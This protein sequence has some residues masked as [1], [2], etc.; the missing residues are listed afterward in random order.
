MLPEIGIT[1]GAGLALGFL[2]AWALG[3]SREQAQDQ[4]ATQL[5]QQLA[6]RS[7]ALETTQR[8]RDTARQE[9][10]TQQQVAA[11]RDAKQREEIAR[12]T[13]EG[14][15]FEQDAEKAANALEE[16]RVEITK[17]RN[18]LLDSETERASLKT[19]LEAEQKHHTKNLATLTDQFKALASDILKENSQTFAAQNQT[20]IDH[21]LEP[22]GK[23][24]ERL[25][26][27]TQELEVKREGAYGAVLTEINNMKDTHQKLRQETTQLVQA[28][29]SPKARGNWGELQLK[30]CIE[31]AGMVERASFDT[32]VFVRGEDQSLRPDCVI[33]L[34]NGRTII[35][36]AKTPFDAYLDAT[37]S[38]DEVQ[39]AALL[40]AHAARVREHLSQL[41]AKA[42]WRQF[43]ESPDFVVCFLS[44]EVLFSAALEQEPGLIEFGSNSNVILATPTTLIALLKAVAY[45][46]QQMEITRNALAIKETGQ[47]LYDKLAT[48]Q[49]YFSKMGRALESAVGQYNSLVGCI[50]GRDSVFDRAREL[51]QLGIGKDDLTELS[52]LNSDKSVPRILKGKD[53]RSSEFDNAP[54]SLAAR[55][56]ETEA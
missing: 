52:P 55:M 9:I 28:L 47:R 39:R 11:E 27:T 49:E 46:W 23:A 42:Y 8:E 41:S 29:R 19:A 56:E 50:E 16:Q 26:S 14:S 54:L 10:A 32:E 24:L 33:H 25:Q 7:A 3:R 1:L 31:F 17:L 53:W 13:A 22:M 15:R 12:L 2:I 51:H 40:A 36:D 34:P 37:I 38:T 35:I 43:K 45:G 30:K 48:T 18:Q 20:N 4:R 44:S 5:E 21:L 6:E